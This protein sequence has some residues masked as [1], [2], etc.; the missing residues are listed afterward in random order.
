MH[1]PAVLTLPLMVQSGDGAT[2][3]Q[4]VVAPMPGRIVRV[5]AA[6]G[7][8]VSFADG[9]PLLVVTEASLEEFE[10]RGLRLGHGVWDLVFERV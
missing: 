7:D 2:G 3:T 4:R 1:S 9:F 10:R 8:E 6:P 5:L